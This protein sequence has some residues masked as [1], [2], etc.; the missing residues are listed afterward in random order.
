[1]SAEMMQAFSVSLGLIKNLIFDVFKVMWPAMLAIIGAYIAWKLGIKYFRGLIDMPDAYDKEGNEKER[2]K[3][4]L[5]YLKDEYEKSQIY[6][7]DDN[8]IFTDDDYW[9][10]EEW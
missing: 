6:E 7:N 3:A 4:E 10:D 1:M 8:E 2:M 9:R 5:D